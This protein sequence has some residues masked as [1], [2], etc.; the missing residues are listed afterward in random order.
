MKDSIAE[1][2]KN[3][4]D[5]GSVGTTVGVL[6]GWLPTS[7][8]ILTVAW[9]AVR[10]YNEVAKAVYWHRKRKLDRRKH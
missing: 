8:A 4:A 3:A 5:L 7:A 9:L 10:L 1:T 6:A 2:V